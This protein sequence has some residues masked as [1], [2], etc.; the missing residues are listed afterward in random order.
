MLDAVVRFSITQRFLIVLGTLALILWG[1][2]SWTRLNLD[3]VPDITTNQVQINTETGGMGPEEV[4][5]LVTFP[6]ETAMAGLPGVEGTR[7]L[8]QYG[9]SQVTVTFKDSVDVFFAR[10]LVNERLG[11][12]VAELP[13]GI[14]A[15]HMGPVSTGLGDIYMFSLESEDRDITALRTMMDWQIAPQLRSVAGVAEINVADGNVKQFQVIA[16]PAQ[17][18]ARGIGVHHLIEALQNNNQNAGG[19]VVESGGERTLIRSVGLAANAADVE[20]IPISTENGTPVLV[21]DVAEVTEGTP[22]VTGLSTKDGKHALVAIAMMLKGANGRA[23][24]QSVDA[25]IQEVRGQLPEDVK[26]TTVYNRAHLVN[27]T[28]GTVEHS[29]LLGGILVVVVLLALLGN[30]RGAL[31]VAVAIPLSM[32]FAIGMMNYWGISG[33]LMSLG[34]IDFGLIVDGAVVMIEN[35]VRRVAERRDH[36]ARTLTREEVRQTVWEASREVAKPT[37]FA[38][39]IITVVYLPILALEGTEG[40]MFKP[41]AFTVVF[42][43]IGALVLTMTLVPA[44]A[45]LF[46]SGDTKEGRNPIMGLLSKLYRSTLNAALKARSLV[47][48]GATALLV[49]AGWLFTTLGSEFIPTLDEGDLVVQPIRIRTVNAEETLRLVTAAEPTS[50]LSTSS[51]RSKGMSR[52]IGSGE[53]ASPRTCALYQARSSSRMRGRS[54]RNCAPCAATSGAIRATARAPTMSA[55]R[56]TASAPQVRPIP[57]SLHQSTSGSATYARTNARTNGAST[58]PATWRSQ[59]NVSAPSG[60]MS[61][62]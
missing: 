27:E 17:L 15:P 43:L 14:E 46:L 8:S 61:R 9:L 35:A 1:I 30:I 38:V 32:L 16:D 26:L 47:V 21:K 18:Q 36:L 7:S 51:A 19:G 11:G 34:A 56:R 31:I 40:K 20:N 3:A 22:V 23:V 53:F 62:L 25:K 33:N 13:Q 24:A 55:R 60:S 28:I 10:Q 48:I 54:V 59:R 50:R 44:L 2:V 29:L 6:V 12:V 5:R 39:S 37:A 52:M 45:S 57:R 58:L 41:M 4:E 49:L 42:A